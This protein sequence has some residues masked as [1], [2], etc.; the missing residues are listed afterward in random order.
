MSRL[1]LVTAIGLDGGLPLALDHVDAGALGG[2]QLAQRAGGARDLGEVEIAPVALDREHDIGERGLQRVDG[3]AHHPAVAALSPALGQDLGGLTRA[4][5]ALAD[6][7]DAPEPGRDRRASHRLPGRVGGEPLPHELEHLVERR[8]ALARPGQR[9]AQLRV[10]ADLV[11]ARHGPLR[12]RAPDSGVAG[13]VLD[14]VLAAPGQACDLEVGQRLERD[15]PLLLEP[16][17][18]AR[19][20][21]VGER[22][23]ERV[24]RG[25]EHGA[26]RLALRL[27]GQDPQDR[28]APV[29]DAL[30]GVAHWPDFRR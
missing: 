18:L 20:G 13:A 14:E 15:Q 6:R 24:E 19:Q 7:V 8:P 26:V 17:Q 22:V 21:V 10:A 2:G 9:L 1:L 5:D 12:L 25:A 11:G 29:P 16:R 30:F 3:G 23:G 27:A 28:V 4:L